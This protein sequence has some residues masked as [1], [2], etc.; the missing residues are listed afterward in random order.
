M[1]AL[2]RVV[3]AREALEDGDV[4]LVAAILR[5]LELDLEVAQRHRVDVAVLADE[6]RLHGEVERGS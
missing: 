1:S 3:R 5:D 6:T 4:E 2:A